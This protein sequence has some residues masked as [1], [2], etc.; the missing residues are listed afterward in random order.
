[1]ALNHCYSDNEAVQCIED[2]TWYPHH[3]PLFQT[4]KHERHVKGVDLG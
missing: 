2:G 3:P 1:M 4:C